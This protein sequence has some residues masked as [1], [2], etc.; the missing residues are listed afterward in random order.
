QRQL[1]DGFGATGQLS[2]WPGSRSAELRS[3][4]SSFDRGFADL[5][6][7][8]SAHQSYFDDLRTQS[9]TGQGRL[10]SVALAFPGAN[11]DVALSDLKKIGRVVAVAESGED[12]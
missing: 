7:V 5:R 12:S 1:P 4:T 3:H 9:Q 11:F 6:R 2:R 10:L 8:V